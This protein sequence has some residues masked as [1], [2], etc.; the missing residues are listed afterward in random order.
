VV[1]VGSCH[2]SSSKGAKKDPRSCGVGLEKNPQ[3]KK[4]L[5]RHAAAPWLYIYIYLFFEEE[6]NCIELLQ[7][8]TG[9]CRALYFWITWL[10][11]IIR[12]KSSGIYGE[13]EECTGTSPVLT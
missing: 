9:T 10:G 7:C 5:I 6:K 13:T 1:G 12:M 2:T 3:L 8:P 4:I 11:L